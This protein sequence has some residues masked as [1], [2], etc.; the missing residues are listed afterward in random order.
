MSSSIILKEFLKKL[1]KLYSNGGV[2]G[3]VGKTA[4]VSSGESDV[5]VF[6]PGGVP[7][8]LN[9]PGFSIVTDEEDSVVEVGVTVVEDT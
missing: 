4:G 6:T 8:V 2:G 5:S 1:S 9:V 7:G 3:G